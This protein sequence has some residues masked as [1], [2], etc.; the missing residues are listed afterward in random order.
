MAACETRIQDAVARM[1]VFAAAAGQANGSVQAAFAALSTELSSHA[2]KFQR[3][4]DVF[5]AGRNPFL[6]RLKHEPRAF[7]ADGACASCPVRRT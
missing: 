3:E 4:A 5:A 7:L 6:P 2:D 1:P